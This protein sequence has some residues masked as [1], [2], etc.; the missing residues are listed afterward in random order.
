MELHIDRSLLAP[1]V[2]SDTTEGERPRMGTTTAPY[3]VTELPEYFAASSAT[4]SLDDG[5]T[6]GASGSTTL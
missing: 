6:K 3:L 5:D 2:T 4:N 1:T